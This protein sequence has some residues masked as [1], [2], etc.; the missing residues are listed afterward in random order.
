[1]I[2]TTKYFGG[3][4]GVGKYIWFRTNDKLD[5]SALMELANNCDDVDICG[6]EL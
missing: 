4:E 5:E 1:M 6:H 3:R 2:P